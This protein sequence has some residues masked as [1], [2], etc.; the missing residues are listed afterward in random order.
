MYEVI[1]DNKII[2]FNNFKN[3]YM[4]LIEYIC[5]HKDEK[6]IENEYIHLYDL[7][8]IEENIKILYKLF[9][10]ININITITTV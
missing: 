9:N 10:D 3:A 4:Y 7:I 1:I 2:H 6:Y 8:T 5:K